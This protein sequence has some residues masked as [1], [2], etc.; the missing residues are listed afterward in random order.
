MNIVKNK[1]ATTKNININIWDDY[2]DD[3]YVPDG[4]RLETFIYVEDTE[5]SHEDCKKFLLYLKE[6]IDSYKLP[7]ETKMSIYD[8]KIEYPNLNF[9]ELQ[10]QHWKRHEIRIYDMTHKIRHELIKKLRK[11]NLK[12]DNKNFNIYSES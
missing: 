6:K 1:N 10:M 5:F 9:E 12:I 11:E 4:E 8:T 3:G 2:Y 7:I